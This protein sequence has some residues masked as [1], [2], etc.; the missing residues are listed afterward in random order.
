M[1]A[2]E[3]IKTLEHMIKTFGDYQ[4]TDTFGNVFACVDLVEN[5]FDDDGQ[6]QLKFK[7]DTLDERVIKV[8]K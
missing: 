3:L 4:V 6:I 1:K 5:F 2:S 8:I 7:D